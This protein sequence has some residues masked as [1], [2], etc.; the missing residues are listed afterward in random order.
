MGIYDLIFGYIAHQVPTISKSWDFCRIS[1]FIVG[2][3]PWLTSTDAKSDRLEN[4][5][6][7]QLVGGRLEIQ[8]EH[9][10]VIMGPI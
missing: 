1:D 8:M 4:L 7:F 5:K 2:S 3:E 10:Y 6:F 9:A